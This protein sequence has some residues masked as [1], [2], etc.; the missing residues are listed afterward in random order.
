MSCVLFHT[1]GSNEHEKT[2]ER[3]D[4]NDAVPPRWSLVESQDHATARQR[5]LLGNVPLR[6]EDDLFAS[7]SHEE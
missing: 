4:A 1:T 2:C 6:R 5:A 3:Q 7:E